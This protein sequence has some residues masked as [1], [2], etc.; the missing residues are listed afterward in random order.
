M[1]T[2]PSGLK[3]RAIIGVRNS[4][5]VAFDVRMSSLL[6]TLQSAERTMGQ[7]VLDMWPF[8]V[9]LAIIKVQIRL[10]PTQL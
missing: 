10:A 7:N 2:I 6:R 4:L 8:L 9:D 3:T 1:G 5:A